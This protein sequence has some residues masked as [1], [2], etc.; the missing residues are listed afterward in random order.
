LFRLAGG[1]L[2]I[3]EAPAVCSS[4]VT[5]PKETVLRSEKALCAHAIAQMALNMGLAWLPMLI[6]V[7]MNILLRPI[8]GRLTVFERHLTHSCEEL[9]A[10][11]CVFVA[12]F[13][14]STNCFRWFN[15][16]FA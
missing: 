8:I 2:S 5:L 3:S 11:R 7:T 14:N 10:F 13:L 16:S 15:P 4:T 12:Q 9:A 1:S 6:V